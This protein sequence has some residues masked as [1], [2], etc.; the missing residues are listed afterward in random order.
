MRVLIVKTSSLGDVLHAL[1]ALTDAVRALPALR[2]DWVVEDSYAEI[3]A[4][5]PAVDRVIAVSLR[6]WR[7]SPGAFPSGARRLLRELRQQ[8]YDCVI[9]AQGLMKSAVLARLARGRRCG[10]AR[11]SVREP[12]ATAAYQQRIAIEVE[13]H[14]VDRLR[15]LFAACLAYPAPTASLDYGIARD[16]FPS[17]RGTNPYLVFLHGTT[18]DSK[19]WP[20]SYWLELAELA[21]A[22]GYDVFVPWGN[23]VENERANRLCRSSK[24]ATQ[25]PA[26]SLTELAGLLAHAAAAV[27]V[28]TGLG[29][30]AAALATPCVSLY[31]A[32]SP[33]RTGTL[34][35]R[36]LHLRADFHCSPCMKRHCVA[37]DPATVRP[38]CYTTVPPALVWSTLQPFLPGYR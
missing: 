18:W 20:E 19:L 31:G 35:D 21:G 16:R 25:L 33:D 32:T 2:A 8:R 37:T 38:P 3:P 4:W 6:H 11:G 15:T 1:P 10:L 12:L 13:K 30:L 34:G 9:D 14:A 28:D 7:R 23:D 36:Q 5:H 22:Q 24:R 17:N 27:A 29:H 26:L